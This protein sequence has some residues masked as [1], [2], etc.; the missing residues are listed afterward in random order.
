MN[1]MRDYIIDTILNNI[2][3]NIKFYYEGFYDGEEHR[4]FKDIEYILKE[5][6]ENESYLKF[7]IEQSDA[8][9]IITESIL[10]DV[11]R[12]PYIYDLRDE[13]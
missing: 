3:Q 6:Y 5:I 1:N 7:F 11:N 12:L 8:L 2:K 13:M 10:T 4:Y 9:M